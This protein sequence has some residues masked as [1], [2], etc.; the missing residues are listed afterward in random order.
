MAAT[1]HLGCQTGALAALLSPSFSLS[2]PHAT[3]TTSTHAQTEDIIATLQ[4]LNLIRFWKGQHVIS[5]SPKVVEDHMKA[6]SRKSLRCEP[7]LLT[8]QP[9]PGT[10]IERRE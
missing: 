1:T 6:N 3:P 4:S 7:H 8:W 2:R 10:V 5:V 9:P